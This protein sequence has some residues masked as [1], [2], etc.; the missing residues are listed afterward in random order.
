LISFQCT[1]RKAQKKLI[2]QDEEKVVCEIQIDSLAT[3]KTQRVEE[4]KEIKNQLEVINCK[5]TLLFTGMKLIKIGELFS[6]Q[7][8]AIVI[9]GEPDSYESNLFLFEKNEEWE[10]KNSFYNLEMLIETEIGFEDFNKDGIDDL[11]VLIGSGGRANFREYL[12]IFNPKSQNI[13]KIKGFEQI[14]NPELNRS[15]NLIESTIFTGTVDYEYYKI[16]GDT[17]MRIRN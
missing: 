13:T 17:L 14:V 15:T 10:L 16:N 2:T 4:I 8:H 12:F 1:Q 3:I 9:A 6:T 7:I 11:T 5:D